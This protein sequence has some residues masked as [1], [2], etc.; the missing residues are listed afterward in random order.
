VTLGT[1]FGIWYY[2]VRTYGLRSDKVPP[3]DARGV[4]WMQ[5]I[6]IAAGIGFFALYGYSVW[7]SYRHW[8][9]QKRVAGDDDLL[10][11][12]LDDPNAPKAAPKPA[13][14]T[15]LRDVKVLP[16][17]SPDTVGIGLGWEIK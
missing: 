7:D 8:E 11:K 2:L 1:S 12:A 3:D 5:R 14:K 9:P 6:E 4:L 10:K 15:S 17:L 13:P 16:M